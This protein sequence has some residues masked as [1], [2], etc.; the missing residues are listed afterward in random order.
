MPGRRNNY[1]GIAVCPFS[2]LHHF[3]INKMPL[4]I[5]LQHTSVGSLQKGGSL[6]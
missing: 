1:F 3:W 2:E 6:P 4:P 5:F